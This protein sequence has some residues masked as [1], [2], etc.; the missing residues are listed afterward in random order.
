MFRS[1]TV[2]RY[3]EAL[4][5]Y[6][7]NFFSHPP[8]FSRVEFDVYCK[9]VFRAIAPSSVVFQDRLRHYRHPFWKSCHLLPDVEGSARLEVCAVGQ[10]QLDQLGTK[11]HQGEVEVLHRG[12][13]GIFGGGDH[14]DITSQQRQLFKQSI[15]QQPRQ[16]FQSQLMLEESRHL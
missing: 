7:T 13:P 9:E 12:Y 2:S 16:N 11:S 15:T 6:S 8:Y 1:Q 3:L 4:L 14:A 5:W 10:L